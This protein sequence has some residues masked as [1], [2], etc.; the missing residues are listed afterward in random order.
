MCGYDVQSPL[1]LHISHFIAFRMHEPG[2]RPG[3]RRPAPTQPVLPALAGTLGARQIAPPIP[4]PHSLTGRGTKTGDLALHSPDTVISP[5]GLNMHIR[6]S[7]V[8]EEAVLAGAVGRGRGGGPAVELPDLDMTLQEHD[9]RS[10]G[11]SRRGEWWE[12]S[13]RRPGP[14]TLL[15]DQGQRG[16]GRGGAA[17]W[18]AGA[19]DVHSAGESKLSANPA[20]MIEARPRLLAQYCRPAAPVHPAQT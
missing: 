18:R 16:E 6:D 15:V 12:L 13:V 17:A 7:S 3:P 20:R 2:P 10:S 19:G 14:L 9:G 1:D 5:A 8:R 11:R 4:S